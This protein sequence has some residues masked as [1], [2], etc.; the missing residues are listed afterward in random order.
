MKLSEVSGDAPKRVKL[1][2]IEADTEKP[3]AAKA[4][5]KSAFEYSLPSQNT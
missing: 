5:G 1:S 2:D 4:F 3:S